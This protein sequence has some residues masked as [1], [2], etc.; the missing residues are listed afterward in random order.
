MRVRK[1]QRLDEEGHWFDDAYAYEKSSGHVVFRYSVAWGRIGAKC[2]RTIRE[3]EVKLE[4]IETVIPPGD[5]LRWLDII[6]IPD[7]E[8]PQALLELSKACAVPEPK[9]KTEAVA[10]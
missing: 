6:I 4:D 1:L 8:S 5:E 10:S 9:L 7:D 3:D 2:N